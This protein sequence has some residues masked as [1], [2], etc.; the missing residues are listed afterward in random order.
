MVSPSGFTNMTIPICVILSTKS[1]NSIECAVNAD[2]EY[3]NKLKNFKKLY[4]DCC[5][6]SKC[7]VCEVTS[8][9]IKSIKKLENNL[10]ININKH[11]L[12]K[13]IDH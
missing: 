3:Y 12:D 5:G 2:I 8:L 10:E 11:I 9:K 7:L 6:Q 1:S 4:G 13:F